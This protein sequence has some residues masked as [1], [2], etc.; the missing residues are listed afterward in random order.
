MAT[1]DAAAAKGL[2]VVPSTEDLRQG[3]DAINERGDELAAEMDA[4]ASGDASKFDKNK[5]IISDTEPTYVA[6]GIWLKPLS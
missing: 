2:R 3:Y 1:G 6:G 5:I 4:R